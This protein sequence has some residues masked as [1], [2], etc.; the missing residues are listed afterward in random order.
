MPRS[1]SFADD[2]IQHFLELSKSYPLITTIL[3]HFFQDVSQVIVL[4]PLHQAI[5]LINVHCESSRV[6]KA[7]HILQIGHG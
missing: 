5:N 4:E 3:Q 6:I 7:A 1:L 2:F